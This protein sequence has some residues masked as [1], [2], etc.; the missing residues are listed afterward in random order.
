MTSVSRRAFLAA[1]AMSLGAP[2]FHAQAKGQTYV[3]LDLSTKLVGARMPAD[4]VGLSYEVQQLADP[5]FF[6]PGN[7]GL[8]R[9]FKALAP[10]GALRLG[11]NTSEFDWWKQSSGS[12]EPDTRRLVWS[13]A[14]LNRSTTP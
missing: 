8:V 9:Q 10:E 14:N 13:K 6:A 2:H 4:F 7:A 5:T 12:P 1:A 3:T 11:G